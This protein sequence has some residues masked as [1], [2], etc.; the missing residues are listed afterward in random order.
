MSETVKHDAPWPSLGRA[1]YVVFI[2][3]LAYTIGY[4]DRVVLTILVEPIQHDLGINDTQIGLLHGLAFVIFYVGLGLPLG[5]LADHTN[6]KRIIVISIAFWS[7]MTMSCGL[8]KSFAGLFLA[9][10]G[11]GVGEAGLSPTSYSLISDYFPP[12]RRSMALGA[13]QLA[14][15]I[16]GG[17]AILIGGWIAAMVGD[18]QSVTLPIL[19]EM[20]SWQ[21]VFMVVGL[22]GMPVSL[23]ALTLKEPARRLGKSAA[24]AAVGLGDQLR[25]LRKVFVRSRYVYLLHFFAFAFQSIVLNVT[26]LWARPY[27]S[28]QFDVSRSDAAY[29]VGSLLLLFATSGILTGSAL[30]DRMQKR[31]HRDA[32]IRVGIIGS[33]CVLIPV[34]LFPFMPTVTLTLVMLALML[35]FAA[36]AVGAAASALQLITPNRARSVISACY[37]FVLNIVALTIGP[38]LTGF[39]TDYVFGT[40]KSVGYSLSIV[41]TLG[42]II[43]LVLFFLLLKPFRLAVEQAE[44]EG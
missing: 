19:G 9:R 23:L 27:L 8:A 34:I 3:I 28:R 41:A 6:R 17:A 39:I 13:Y 33:S 26:L 4:V 25:E 30:A 29:M 5:Y 35:F 21:V 37:L 12:E 2:L 11:V 16:G 7:V 22:L 44:R 20:R 40:P 36:F 10:V 14:I 38:T 1:W 15:Y 24:N 43:S 31:G 32:T 42:V 18:K